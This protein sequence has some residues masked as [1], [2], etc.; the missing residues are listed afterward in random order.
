MIIQCSDILVM[1]LILE[2]KQ[3]STDRVAFYTTIGQPFYGS[4][5]SDS[6]TSSYHCSL[7]HSKTGFQVEP[8]GVMTHFTCKIELKVHLL[9]WKKDG[10]MMSGLP[11]SLV[12]WILD[13]NKRLR[14]YFL[15]LDQPCK[16]FKNLL[17]LPQRCNRQW[18]VFTIPFWLCWRQKMKPGNSE[19]FFKELQPF[20]FKIWSKKASF[21]SPFFIMHSKSANSFFRTITSSPRFNFIG[22][23]HHSLAYTEL[24]ITIL[25]HE[26][27]DVHYLLVYV[28]ATIGSGAEASRK[29]KYK[30]KSQLTPKTDRMSKVNK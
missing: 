13:K 27:I 22:S 24:K 3:F 12:N 20:L 10:S 26:L 15:V 29:Y 18:L 25:M 7:T 14:L 9:A 28:R 5:F 11:Q 23:S 19:T 16:H 2:Q 17:D 21:N 30:R 6:M 1:T 8:E 4:Q